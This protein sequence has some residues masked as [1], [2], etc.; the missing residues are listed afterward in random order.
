MAGILRGKEKHEVSNIITDIFREKKYLVFQ[1]FVSNAG[2][3]AKEL[4]LCVV[5]GGK[6][7][8]GVARGR[9]YIASCQVRI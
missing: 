9:I 6:G 5:P 3:G 4:L 7:V 2:S 1:F 8:E